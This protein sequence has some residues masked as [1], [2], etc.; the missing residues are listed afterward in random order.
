MMRLH[1]CVF[2]ATLVAAAMLS[3]PAA[4]AGMLIQYDTEG[5]G[6]GSPTATLVNAINPAA[7]VT[8]ID[9]TRGPGLTPI[10]ASFALNSS[11]WDNLTAGDRFYQFGFTTTIPYAVSQLTV[12]LR[13]SA[14]G[15]GFVDL[16]YSKDG[17]A[18]TSLSSNPIEL[19]GTNFNDLTESLAQIGVVDSSLLF[20]LVV[21]PNHATSAGFNADPTFPSAIGP[22]G[23]FR[24]ASF[25]PSANVIVNPAITGTAVATGV[26]EPSTLTLLSLGSLGLVGYGWRRR[27]RAS[28]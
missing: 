27:N 24:F 1:R 16:L 4:W 7:G 11:G 23:T 12:G 15:P 21:D 28:A 18:F 10:S 3:A 9:V 22:I 2:V 25:S 5:I 8:G 19:V 13:S 17:G 26:P 20:K 14:T 6:P